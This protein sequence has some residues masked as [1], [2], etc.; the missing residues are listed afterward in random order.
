MRTLLD[1]L[2]AFFQE[3]RRWCGAGQIHGKFRLVEGGPGPSPGRFSA[4]GPVQSRQRAKAPFPS[5]GPLA[6]QDGDQGAT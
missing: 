3:H 5:P 4:S 2:D 1:D 6:G